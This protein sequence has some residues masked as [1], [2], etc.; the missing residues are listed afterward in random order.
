MDKTVDEFITNYEVN[1][2]CANCCEICSKSC[3]IMR[4]AHERYDEAV[5]RENEDKRGKTEGTEKV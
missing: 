4:K 1:K 5:R 2:F 3:A